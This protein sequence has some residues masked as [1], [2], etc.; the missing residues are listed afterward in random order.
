MN[1]ELTDSE[2][3]LLV[4]AE[5]ED[6]VNIEKYRAI[7]VLGVNGKNPIIQMDD[8]FFTGCCSITT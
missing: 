7:H 4:Y 5:F 1:Q 3:E 8:T 6:T 2:E